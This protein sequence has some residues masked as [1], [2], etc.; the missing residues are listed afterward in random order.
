MKNDQ[1][2]DPKK[3]TRHERFFGV[4]VKMAILAILVLVGFTIYKNYKTK[5]SG[6]APYIEALEMAR[7]SG[8]LVG[9]Y[10]AMTNMPPEHFETVWDIIKDRI[11]NYEPT[12]YYG[13]ANIH[14][15][16]DLKD[17][18]LF[19]IFLARFRL[20]YDAQ[21]CADNDAARKWYEHFDGRFMNQELWAEYIAQ[22]QSKKDAMTARLL[23]RVL[24][25]DA[26]NFQQYVL[27]LYLCR[28]SIVPQHIKDGG[29]SLMGDAAQ[30]GF[31]RQALRDITQQQIDAFTQKD[32]N[33]GVNKE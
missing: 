7:I 24:A 2:K 19:W 20:S 6:A 3:K 5:I 22:S 18:A 28:L 17:E 25:W 16:H 4:I 30:W 14:M 12:L 9:A 29:V 11:P 26:A 10:D 33:T 15:R 23:T 8:D 31:M 27:P 32:M 21:L 13:L 1:I